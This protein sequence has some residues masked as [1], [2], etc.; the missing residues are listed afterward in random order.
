[1]LCSIPNSFNLTIFTIAVFI[2]N[3]HNSSKSGEGKLRRKKGRRDWMCLIPAEELGLGVLLIISTIGI[4]FSSII[5]SHAHLILA[6]FSLQKMSAV[7]NIVS[8]CSNKSIW[9]PY[10]SCKMDNFSNCIN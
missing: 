6:I 3:E 8:S 1:T 5:S 4:I 9:I 10:N 2:G 7:F